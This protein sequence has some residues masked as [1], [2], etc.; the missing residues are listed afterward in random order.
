MKFLANENFPYPSIAYLRNQGFDILSI[1]ETRFGIRDEEVLQIAQDQ[2]RT[3]LTF[4]RDYGELIFK[5]RCRPE[6]GVVYF[7]FI[8][9]SPLEA[10]F[11]LEAALKTPITLD[12]NLTVLERDNIRQ[13]R[14]S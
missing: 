5:F 11:V 7:R 13:R 6:K 9:A 2:G 1:G 14:Y 10:G 4:D 3:I 8:P 12:N